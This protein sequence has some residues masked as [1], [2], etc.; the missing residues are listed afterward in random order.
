MFCKMS[1]LWKWY[2]FFFFFIKYM[3]C[4][5]LSVSDISSKLLSKKLQCI[6]TVYQY[7]KQF[8]NRFTFVCFTIDFNFSIFLL[9][10]FFYIN[11]F[12]KDHQCLWYELQNDCDINAHMCLCSMECFHCFLSTIHVIIFKNIF[13]LFNKKLQYFR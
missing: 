1:N 5:L 6:Y 10:I 7:F 3:Y 8:F 9:G 11:F 4:I 2:N 13:K 12:I